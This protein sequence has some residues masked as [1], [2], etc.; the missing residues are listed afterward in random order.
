MFDGEIC[1]SLGCCGVPLFWWIGAAFEQ[2]GVGGNSMGGDGWEGCA[3]SPCDWVGQGGSEEYAYCIFAF[4][5]LQIEV[6][7]GGVGLRP[8]CVHT[9]TYMIYFTVEHRIT[10]YPN[11]KHWDMQFGIAEG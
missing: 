7:G 8:I 1:D 5:V 3:G 2:C 11:E 4:E 6:E 10:C 9:S